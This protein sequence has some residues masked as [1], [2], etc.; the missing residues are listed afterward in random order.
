[1]AGFDA[2]R[3]KLHALLKLPEADRHQKHW[4]QVRVVGTVLVEKLVEN[5]GSLRTWH[6]LQVLARLLEALGREVMVEE[7]D[8]AVVAAGW[9]LPGEEKGDG[10]EEVEIGGEEE[11]EDAVP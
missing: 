1:L 8:W 11:G 6:L 7:L 10:V 9:R 3:A 4:G 5:E 2:R